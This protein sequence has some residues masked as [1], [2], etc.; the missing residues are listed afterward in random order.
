MRG[1]QESK[2]FQVL[3]E[4]GTLI[5]E[6]PALSEEDL[7]ALYRWMVWVREYDERGMRLQRQG[8]IAFF[9]PCRGQEAAHLGSAYA[10]NPDDWIF[11]QY[12]EPGVALLRGVPLTK[13]FH[14]LRGDSEDATKGR[15]LSGL[16]CFQEARLMRTATPVGCQIPWAVGFSY[17]LKLHNRKE[18][19]LV[20]F[21]DGA[22]SRGDFHSALNFAGVFQTPTLF[23]CQNNHYAISCPVAKQ[24]A[25][26]S[27]AVKAQAYGFEGRRV[28]GNDV[29]AVYQATK[30]A[31][32]YVRSERK[33]FLIEAVTYRMGPH[34][35]ADDPTRYRPDEELK[36]WEQK[37]PLRRF[38]MYLEKKG[39]LDEEA[40]RKLREEVQAQIQ[41][42]VRE[43]EKAPLPGPEALIEDVYAEVPPF[44]REE[45]TEILEAKR[46]AQG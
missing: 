46:A 15:D 6:E 22:T 39:L 27:I 11:L 5:G 12:R 14:Q 3:C 19:V 2:P 10:L 42:A 29:L 16:F 35:T 18:I 28:D 20:Y 17:A 24:T 8:R 13:L 26:K 43:A 32:E 33:P 30:E 23:F 44:L 40:E 7:K 25:S 37:D 31:A 9:S 21:G 38:R 1:E 41:E 4:D 34:T 45:L 36:Q